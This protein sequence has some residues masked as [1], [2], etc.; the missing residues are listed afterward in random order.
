MRRM[1]GAVG[2][3]L[4]LGATPASLLA[5]QPA[6]TAEQRAYEAKV[7]DMLQRQQPQT[8]DIALPDAKATLHL[9]KDYYYLD[10]KAAREV[11]VD[12]WGNPAAQA[13]G[14]LGL[15]FPAGKTFLDEDTWGAVITYDQSGYVKDDDVAS[16][17]FDALMTDMQSGEEERNKERADAGYPPVHLVGWAERPA[18][19]RAHHSVVWARNL[20]FGSGGDGSLNYDVRL[21]GRF[22]V[23]SLNM[24]STMSHLPEVKAA[25]SKFGASVTFDQGAR[26]ADF[27][28][29]VDKVAEYG[30]SGLVAAGAGLLAAKKLGFLALILAFGKKLL[31]PIILFFG[32]GW[33]WIKTKFSRNR[34]EAEEAVAYDAPVEKEAE[35][36]V[37]APAESAPRPSES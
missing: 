11:I 32:V 24:I 15:V 20:Q 18:Y 37:E 26:Y 7:K 4:L 12:A 17:D 9:G 31:I 30:I 10:A 27:V 6:P 28:P 34:P 16:T 1:W 19:D 36:A 21:L 23:L 35:P 3:M 2:A 14:V 8:G 29:D 33:R 25:A 22:G 13:D 5:Q